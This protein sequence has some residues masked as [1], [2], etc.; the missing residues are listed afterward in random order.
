MPLK[1]CVQRMCALRVCSACGGMC[2]K[3]GG[4][5]PTLD[6][7]NFD[8]S[9]KHVLSETSPMRES[10]PTHSFEAVRTQSALQA[11]CYVFHCRWWR[12]RLHDGNDVLSVGI[13]CAKCVSHR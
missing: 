9:P 13:A 10:G 12:P 4:N 5:V 1:F 7:E 6:S 11:E 8:S 3:G 2:C